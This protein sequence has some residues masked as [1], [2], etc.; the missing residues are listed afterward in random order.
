[1]VVLVI[2]RMLQSN[3][4]ESKFNEDELGYAIC[5]WYMSYTSE[6][7]TESLQSLKNKDPIDVA[8][9]LAKTEG[10]FLSALQEYCHH[11]DVRKAAEVAREAVSINP[12]LKT[13]LESDWKGEPFGITVLLEAD[14]ATLPDTGK[15]FPP[16]MPINFTH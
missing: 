14:L 10:P 6:W 7:S 8:T 5:P 13:K 12:S 16:N 2:Q 9:I 4:S 15:K 3:M 1:M 11:G